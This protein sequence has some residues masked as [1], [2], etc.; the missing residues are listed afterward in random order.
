MGQ[1]ILNGGYYYSPSGKTLL[2]SSKTLSWSY[3]F[4]HASNMFVI[5]NIFFA[6]S[7]YANIMKLKNY[8]LLSAPLDSAGTPYTYHNG[9]AMFTTD[10]GQHA[11]LGLALQQLP[12]KGAAT[13]SAAAQ[14]FP[15]L[16]GR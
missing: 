2:F 8:L 1:P 12:A 5:S 3:A 9:L 11:A 13:Q 4:L 6:W 15:L 14:P 7:L 10:T 16:Y